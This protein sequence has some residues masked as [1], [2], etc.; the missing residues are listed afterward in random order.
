MQIYCRIVIRDRTGV[1]GF[2]EDLPVL[3]FV[4]AGTVT[5]VVSAVNVTETM[6]SYRKQEQLDGF[7]ER[8]A[9]LLLSEL[10][11]DNPDVSVIV[12][13]L[14]CTRLRESVEGFLGEREFAITL[15][16]LHPV[17]IFL[18][19]DSVMAGNGCRM[20]SSASRLMNAATE[21]GREGILAVR[22]V[23]W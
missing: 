19:Q 21:D 2:F 15:V 4:L 18:Y 8:S 12:G 23:V 9:D 14:C 20:S 6:G 16:M 17:L 7:A 11:S 10:A 13:S 3:M 5:L 1:A 22:I